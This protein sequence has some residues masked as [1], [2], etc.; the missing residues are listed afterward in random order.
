MSPAC[1]R[2]PVHHGVSTSPHD[3]S[4]NPSTSHCTNTPSMT[5]PSDQGAIITWMHFDTSVAMSY[6]DAFHR[7]LP[8]PLTF[9]SLP[10]HTR[11]QNDSSTGSVSTQSCRCIVDGDA[12][13]DDVL[14]SLNVMRW[15]KA[16]SA[17]INVH[18]RLAIAKVHRRPMVFQ[19]A[20]LARG[21]N[22]LNFNSVT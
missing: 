21:S 17:V 22:I 12:Q 6:R 5:L 3:Y 9:K 13:I 18:D 4:C 19:R 14:G 16:F 2:W 20:K 7:D 8:I 11:P 1:P 15:C 10:Y